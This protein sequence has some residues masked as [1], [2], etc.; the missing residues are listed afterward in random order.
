MISTIV[1]TCNSWHDQR[2]PALVQ[3]PRHGPTQPISCRRGLRDTVSE[4]LGRVAEWQTRWLQVPVSFGTWGFKSP[5]AHFTRGS[6]CSQRARAFLVSFSVIWGRSP[7]APLG[8]ASPPELPRSMVAPRVGCV[9]GAAGVA[10][11]RARSVG[12][13]RCLG[14]LEFPAAACG[15]R[16][17]A[18][19][20]VCDFHDR[21][22]RRVCSRVNETSVAAVFRFRAP[23]SVGVLVTRVGGVGFSGMRGLRVWRYIHKLWTTADIHRFVRREIRPVGVIF[24]YFGLCT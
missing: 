14:V 12:R 2:V 15:V 16:C 21:R 8:G 6:S 5:F 4:S 9:C 13:G 20:A 17:T 22:V 7:H 24:G 11:E 10:G 19:A 23:G 18:F 1:H 3:P